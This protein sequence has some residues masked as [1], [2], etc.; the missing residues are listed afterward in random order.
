MYTFLKPSLKLFKSLQIFIASICIFLPYILKC[1]DHDEFYPSQVQFSS[2]EGIK[3]CESKYQVDSIYMPGKNYCSDSILRIYIRECGSNNPIHFMD[4]I[5]KDSCKFRMS[6]SDYVNSSKSYLFG[7][8]YCMAAMLFI[9]NAAIF[10]RSIK[11]EKQLTALPYSTIFNNRGPLYNLIIGFSLLC[12]IIFPQKEF[13]FLHNLFTVIFFVGNLVV[14][15]FFPNP[16]DS[17][18]LKAIRK[19][20]VLIILAVLIATIKYSILTVLY[21]EWISLT[22]FATHL[23][24]AAWTIKIPVKE[25]STA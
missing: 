22:V 1:T 10:W 3:N 21:A 19:V 17:K 12:V 20:I 25:N 2:L 7:M 24:W 13:C 18:F 14:V 16:G 5:R 8:L 9:F 6:I 11:L 4:R 15:G 23:I